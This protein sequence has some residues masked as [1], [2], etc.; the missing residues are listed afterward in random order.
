MVEFSS[1]LVD[2]D[3]VPNV[4]TFSSLFQNID[5]LILESGENGPFLSLNKILSDGTFLYSFDFYNRKTLY[6]HDLKG[7]LINSI[8]RVGKGPEEYVL[9]VDFDLDDKN[10]IIEILDS[11]GA[12]LVLD[13]KGGF[14]R[15]IK[16][17]FIPTRFKKV[18]NENYLFYF[19]NERRI[20]CNMS[21]FNVK[22]EKNDCLMIFDQEY[23]Y[24]RNH[25]SFT[26]NNSGNILFSR[27]F[28]NTIYKF[29]KGNMEPFL[30]IDFGEM[31]MKKKELA[32]LSKMS[33]GEASLFLS[34]NSNTC[35][36]MSIFMTNEWIINNYR[37]QFNPYLFYHLES[38]KKINVMDITNDVDN[39]L[40]SIF[41]MGV[42]DDC[43]IN[44]MSTRRIKEHYLEQ[45]LNLKN[46]KFNKMVSQL[47]KNDF[48]V[49]SFLK[50]KDPMNM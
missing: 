31:G 4:N 25:F 21:L 43:L 16:L 42:H 17:P 8:T 6:I 46:T 14:V 20:G 41:I 9:P 47:D 18:D 28:D 40:S 45:N 23:P 13:K 27:D 2:M 7:N 11:R 15:R 5:Y 10:G 12:I 30:Q 34:N 22:S 48:V 24:V 38:G 19:L 50:I 3:F 32:Q 1:D 29:S 36:A 39:G 49:L 37:G 33:Y 44:I 26:R 35:N